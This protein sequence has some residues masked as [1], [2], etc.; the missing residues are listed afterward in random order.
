MA[1]AATSTSPRKPGSV[2]R[3]SAWHSDLPA[4]S[5]HLATG[6]QQQW[7]LS[8]IPSFQLQ[9]C[10]WQQAL[11]CQ[12][13]AYKHNNPKEA[14]ASPN[15]TFHFPCSSVAS[16]SGNSSSHPSCPQDRVQSFSHVR[17]FVTP[18]T[19]ALQ[20]SLPIKSSRILLKL[21]SIELVMLSNH[22]ILCC[23]LLILPSIFPSIRVFSNESVFLH[24]VATVW[25]LQFQHQSFQWIFRTDSL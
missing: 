9:R 20:A 24:H 7:Q 12:C 25:E 22:L 19:A 11:C 6:N 10:M 3:G 16:N 23:S 15:H 2:R 17:L 14:S 4:A 8:V 5:K 13:S 18:W 21:M 1:K